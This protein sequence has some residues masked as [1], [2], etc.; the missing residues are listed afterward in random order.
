MLICYLHD[1]V[2]LPTT[3]SRTE[4]PADRTLIPRK[5]TVIKWPHLKTVAHELQPYQPDLEIGLL[6]GF[7]CSIALLPR[8]V[9]I[10]GDNDPYAMRT[11]LGWG[12]VGIVD[13][14]TCNINNEHFS[15]RTQ[16]KEITN[17]Q[18]RQM[19][20]VDF[21]EQD[22]NERQSRDDRKFL[23]TLKENIHQR[24]DGHYQMPLPFRIDGTTLPNNK[25]V[26]EKRLKG[27]KGKLSRQD[28]FKQQYVKF[29]SEMMK[30]GY[31]EKVPPDQ[32]KGEEERVW[33]LP[34]HGVYHPQKP[35]KLRVVFDCS[36]EYNGQSL[37]QHLFTW[38]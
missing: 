14:N 23:S 33:Y 3:Y 35:E 38:T 6:I 1:E 11:I 22:S 20:E 19:F 18:V 8:E 37:N 5:E 12:V 17:N 2:C 7:N 21:S 13:K 28:K 32:M 27:L 9:V 36:A 26:V 25:H 29:M 10:A 4:I 16:V 31:A 34:H 24:N 15:F 30:N